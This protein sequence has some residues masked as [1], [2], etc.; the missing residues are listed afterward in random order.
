MVR[1]LPDGWHVKHSTTISYIHFA[2]ITI[3]AADPDGLQANQG[4]SVEVGSDEGN[5]ATVVVFDL[6]SVADNSAV[7]PT[8]VSGD[9]WVVLDVQ[10]N[11]ETVAGIALTLGDETIH[12]RGSSADQGASPGLA[13]SGGTEYNCLLKTA[14]TMGECMGEQLSPMYA[15]GEHHVGA[16]ITT[17]DGER[18]DAAATLPVTLKNNSYVDVVHHAGMS[19]RH[20]GRV[21]HGG[22]SGEGN[23][24]SFSAC[25]V[26][27]E[28]TMVGS[29][30]L[31]A[32]RTDTDQMAAEGPTVSFQTGKDEPDNDPSPTLTEAPYT[33][34]IHSEFNASV[35]TMA[36]DEFWVVNSGS[37][38]DDAGN[39]VTDEFRKAGEA[40][41]GP[42]H[43]DFKAPTLED[44][45]EIQLAEQA[46]AAG[47]SY[48]G[49]KIM[50]KDADFSL[51][52][53]MDMGVGVSNAMTKFAV[54]DCKANETDTAKV[55]R[56]KVDFMA[57]EGYE[58]VSGIADLAEEDAG[59]NAKTDKT[60]VDCY[61]AEVAMLVDGLGNAWKGGKTP[62]SWLQ[63]ANFGVD[64]TAPEIKNF[65]HDDGDV[66]RGSVVI[67]FEVDNPTGED[68]STDSATELSGMVTRP[69]ATSAADP[70][71]AGTAAA[72]G[73]D[74]AD[75]W[76][77]TVTGLPKDG[78]Y[79]IT[80][81]VQDGATPPNKD[82]KEANLLYDATPPTFAG[83]EFLADVAGGLTATI[84]VA[85]SVEDKTSGIANYTLS[86]WVN[87]GP[88]TAFCGEGDPADP[89][90]SDR[91][92]ATAR[93]P[94]DFSDARSGRGR[95]S[96]GIPA[97]AV[98]P[99]TPV[100]SAG[101]NL[102]VE[103]S[104]TDRAGNTLAATD[105]AFVTVN[106][107]QNVPR[108][109]ITGSGAAGAK[110]AA[111]TIF[112]EGA[113]LPATL[114]IALGARP[115]G[116]VTIEFTSSDEDVLPAPEDLV[117]A[118]AN[119]T[120]AVAISN[121]PSQDAATTAR[122]APSA[123]DDDDASDNT[124]TI[125]A[126]ATGGG[127]NG[128][129]A[130]FTVVV[131]DDDVM[132]TSDLEDDEVPRGAN[133]T[134]SLT[135]TRSASASVAGGAAEAVT[136]A[137]AVSDASA[138]AVTN[139]AAGGNLL[140]TIP[141]GQATASATFTVRVGGTALP[142]ETI[143]VS[144]SGTDIPATRLRPMGGLVITVVN[145]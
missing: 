120:T 114:L 128:Q 72:V 52:G 73:G 91:P 35:E 90:N 3:T 142:G 41:E 29:L 140:I 10:S 60:D 4:F 18:R 111:D 129:R 63:T 123:T 118:E 59:R 16:F 108:I 31:E 126:E 54:G 46:I 15:N 76:T 84:D 48:S 94:E 115:E 141:A 78:E 99:P 77:A 109:L 22:P 43:F 58:D 28:G 64:R 93:L 102:C 37:I 100:P 53:A 117:L 74:D 87:S 122:P 130:R 82:S 34:T 38:M 50:K 106:W 145:P 56:T 23:M 36:G 119:A 79:D 135:A 20:G 101:E 44:D 13:A 47:T 5:P 51:M 19:V 144:A 1:Q 124:V 12:C 95:G 27:Y 136:V 105:A 127:Y 21:F 116:D 61:V 96:I 81:T 80:V 131:T 71:N 32:K 125:T 17:A 69:G 139:P 104:A 121:A 30:T 138:M 98:K 65:S 89:A 112:A 62:A 83:P 33:W 55:D 40:M 133:T 39:D 97:F 92:V 75:D 137:F 67:G 86:V 113:D 26:S 25:P 45:A 57:I 103:V 6:K 24:N 2:I 14:A 7:D 110:V 8:N 9:V 107:R 88:A 66:F 68:G 143:T 49:G 85:G 132:L 70:I 42:L 134:V 11:D